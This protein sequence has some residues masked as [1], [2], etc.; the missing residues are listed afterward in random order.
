MGIAIDEPVQNPHVPDAEKS[1]AH[2]AGGAYPE[3][4]AGE[5]K[6][7]VHSG[8]LTH[9]TTPAASGAPC[10][11]DVLAYADA[12]YANND[13][14][15]EGDKLSSRAAILR[16][17]LRFVWGPASP[18]LT[19]PVQLPQAALDPSSKDVE[20]EAQVA[21]ELENRRALRKV[22]AFGAFY[23]IT[24]DILGPFNT[25]YAYS[26]VGFGRSTRISSSPQGSAEPPS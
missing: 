12:Q 1:Q 24:T 10:L 6:G 23:L 11:E 15:N 13:V 18:A 8:S 17:P 7:S 19:A 3:V 20:L 16:S 25:G 5:E 21:K 2:G 26:T 4:R 22:T 9:T 14:V